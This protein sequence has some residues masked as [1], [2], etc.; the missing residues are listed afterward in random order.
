[1]KKNSKNKRDFKYPGNKKEKDKRKR[2]QDQDKY[3]GLNTINQ[4]S[5]VPKSHSFH[6]SIPIPPSRTVKEPLPI[7]PDCNERIQGIAESFRL[8]SGEFIHFDCMLK[9]IRAAENLKENQSISY[10]GRGNF[11]VVEKNEEGKYIIVRTIPVEE[12]KTFNEMK[13]FVEGLKV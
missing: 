12:E 7:C 13:E 4:V 9:R 8:P 3:Q 11:A 5:G 10:I 2:S 1:M 6:S